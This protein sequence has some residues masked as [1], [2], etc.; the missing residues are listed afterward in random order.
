MSV[1]RLSKKFPGTL[2]NLLPL[3]SLNSLLQLRW[4]QWQGHVSPLPPPSLRFLR[5]SLPPSRCRHQ[6][7]SQDNSLPIDPA[8]PQRPGFLFWEGQVQNA[9]RTMQS[10]K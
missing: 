5:I 6:P 9:Q 1:A 4:Q 7:G 3:R 8:S 2:S 10:A